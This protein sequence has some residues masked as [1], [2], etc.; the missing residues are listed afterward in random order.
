MELRRLFQSIKKN[1]TQRDGYFDN[2]SVSLSRNFRI[3]NN[4]DDQRGDTTTVA[5]VAHKILPRT[6]RAAA[7]SLLLF[8]EKKLLTD[9]NG[10]ECCC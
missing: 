6:V 9:Y 3:S 10:V 1:F 2:L 5:V 8:Q 4:T 7:Y